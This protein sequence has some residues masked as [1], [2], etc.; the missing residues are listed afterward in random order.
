M[1]KASSGLFQGTVGSKHC[2]LIS[3]EEGKVS[4]G[5][6][7]ILGKNL[8]S[9]MGLKRTLKWIG[10]QAQHIIPAELADHPV[11]QKIGINLDHH[12]NGIFLRT[13]S[14]EVSTL[15]RHFGYHA[16]YN[17]FARSQL[18]KLNL[19]SSSYE[20]QREV[21]IL[22]SN[23]RKMQSSGAVIYPKHGATVDS[24]ERAYNRIAKL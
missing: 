14:T 21:K 10:Y 2:R 16:P 11:L 23:L 7:T 9:S 22:Q 19:S 20:L 1:S 5:N 3:G 4:G 24:I 17:K 8:L 12:T 15:T 6:S 13:P 18:D